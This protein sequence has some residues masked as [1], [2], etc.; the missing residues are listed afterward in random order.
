MLDKK[1][2]IALGYF[3]GVHIGH[4]KVIDTAKKT[5]KNLGAS[6]TL[7]SFDSNLRGFLGEK[8][9]A[10]IYNK[11]ERQKIYKNLGVD[12]VFFAPITKEFLSLQPTEFLQFL[13]KNFS[14]L[15]YVFGTDYRFG[16]DGLGSLTDIEKF[17]KERGQITVPVEQERK[18]GQIISATLI[19]NLLSQGN[20]KGANS[21][22]TQ[23]YFI[24]GVVVDGKKVGRTLGYPTINIKIENG[25]HLLKQGVYLGKVK[26]DREYKAIINYGA[27]PTFNESGVILEAHLLDFN[28]DL[29]KK[30]IDVEFIDYLRDIVKFSS[31]DELINQLQKDKEKVKSE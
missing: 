7:F 8:D 31:K 24:S 1:T 29:Y 15:A 9:G 30:T 3:D 21:L 20:V 12:N 4:K 16:K 28:G 14:I 13:N 22:L 2:V 10:F 26:L 27:R 11:S 23:N 19:K 25:K 6:F 17:A 5:A 18:S